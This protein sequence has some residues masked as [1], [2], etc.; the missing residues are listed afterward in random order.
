ME[1]ST[2]ALQHWE[3]V[4]GALPDRALHCIPAAALCTPKLCS[5]TSKKGTHT[6]LQPELLKLAQ[7]PTYQWLTANFTRNT[8]GFL[9]H[10]VHGHLSPSYFTKKKIVNMH[11]QKSNPAS[12]DVW[13]IFQFS[14][15]PDVSS[16]LG[17]FKNS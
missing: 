11:S 7:N 9:R 8:L 16:L 17:L 10:T 12:Q 5:P 3:P 13:R 15:A 4:P 2:W 6:K 1:H 14:E